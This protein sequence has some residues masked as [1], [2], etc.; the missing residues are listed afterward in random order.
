MKGLI[1]FFAAILFLV[2]CNL[3]GGQQGEEI[4]ET[5]DNK[6]RQILQE[7]KNKKEI[8]EDLGNEVK[9]LRPKALRETARTLGIQKGTKWRYEQIIGELKKYRVYLD[10]IF[11]FGQLLLHE[12]KVLPPVIIQARQG[13]NI[14]S[15]KKATSVDAVYK[16]LKGASLISNPPS[17]RDYLVRNYVSFQDSQVGIV[18]QNEEE[19]KIWEKAAENGWVI[20]VKNADRLYSH[21]L[22]ELARDFKG[23]LL[24]KIL[25]EKNIV[26]VPMLAQGKLGIQVRD[27]RLD[28][29]QRIFRITKDSVFNP[30]I[31][32]WKPK[33]GVK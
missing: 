10:Q 6:G 29:D 33:V 2:P 19:R 21:N 27:K 16:I 20:G 28:V 3:F 30:K 31:N 7:I 13:Y 25:D 8:H 9:K 11:D 15:E 18:P 12:G 26:S 14:E 23:I 24:F 22:H 1:V 17:W 4:V 5:M 32:E